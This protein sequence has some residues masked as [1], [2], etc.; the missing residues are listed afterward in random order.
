MEKSCQYVN[1]T[2]SLSNKACAKMW[3]SAN[4]LLGQ[5]SMPVNEELSQVGPRKLRIKKVDDNREK[6]KEVI[7]HITKV[8]NDVPRKYFV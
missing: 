3:N 6:I 5:F 2:T 8:N 7:V 4:G 1:D